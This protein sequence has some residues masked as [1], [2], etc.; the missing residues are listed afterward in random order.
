MTIFC[1]VDAQE[2]NETIFRG[3]V[4]YTSGLGGIFP[5]GLKVGDVKETTLLGDTAEIV[6]D[7][8]AD[9]RISPNVYIIEEE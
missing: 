1:S 5:R 7:L 9:P 2:I 6:I 8:A 4:V 3:Q